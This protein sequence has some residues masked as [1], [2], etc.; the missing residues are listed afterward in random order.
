[1]EPESAD[2]RTFRVAVFCEPDEPGE[3]ADVLTEVLGIHPT[4]AMIHSRLAPGILPDRLSCEQSE[5]LVAA[6]NGL[7]LRAESVSADE[8]PNFGHGEAV[9]HVQ[10]PE[11]G[12]DMV[13]LCGGLDDCVPWDE[14]EL[15][16]VGVIPQET[17]KHYLTNEMATL[18]AARRTTHG[19]L[20]VPL[21][22]GPELWF[23]RRNPPHAYRVD[24]KRM[25]YEYLGGRKTDSATVN[26]RL[27]LDDL[28]RRSPHA[29]VTPSTRAFLG[30]AA[31]RL[32]HFDSAEQLQRYTQFHCLAHR[33]AAKQL[34]ASAGIGS[35]TVAASDSNFSGKLP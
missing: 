10:C 31:E 12:L 23:I 4:D 24:H 30:H 9:H 34:S 35:E 19:P 21:S 16:C 33:R 1:M 6:I 3:L 2:G 11:A 5:R 32:Y 17:T 29:Y 15:I 13:G 20:E 27:F 28:L 26:F 25:N 8:I 18:S 7:G 22:T 14:I